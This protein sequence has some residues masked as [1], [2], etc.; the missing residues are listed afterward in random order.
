[1]IQ[2]I[3]VSLRDGG[4][5]NNFQFKEMFACESVKNIVK[6]GIVFVEVG[7]RNGPARHKQNMGLTAKTGN[8]YLKKLR[9]NAPDA[10]LVVMVHPHNVTDQDLESL[11]KYDVSLVRVCVNQNNLPD[12][13]GLIKKI[14]RLG[15]GVTANFMRITQLKLGDMVQNAKIMEEAG[16][17]VVYF[18]DSNG[19]L[20][21]NQ[22]AKII[23]TVKE[24]IRC[25]IG[26]HA[27]NNLSLALPNSI[28]AMEAGATFIDSSLTGF[29]KGGG[30]LASEVFI[31]YLRKMGL[32]EKFDLETIIHAAVEWRHEV[33]KTQEVSSIEELLL[34][35]YDFTYEEG[36]KMRN[37]ASVGAAYIDI[38]GQANKLHSYVNR[39][40]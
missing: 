29:G 27:H 15:L 38:L 10:K 13:L 32:G 20:L 39:S 24:E 28:A 18:A 14:K 37:D 31:S 17:D 3:D 30:N 1:M 19:S 7:Y 12:C 34:G 9:G 21:P 26:F 25:E 40:H 2:I 22:T 16:V 5:K 23:S 36:L 8:H 4:Y 33:E 6:A 11:K 35:H